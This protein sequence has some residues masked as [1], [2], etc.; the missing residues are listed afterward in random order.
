LRKS[1]LQITNP[2]AAAGSLLESDHALNHSHVMIAPKYEI[3]VE[4]N[5]SLGQSIDVVM[6]SR[7]DIVFRYLYRSLTAPLVPPLPVFSGRSCGNTDSAPFKKRVKSVSERRRGEPLLEPFH[8][9][10]FILEICQNVFVFQ[11]A[12]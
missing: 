1:L 8:H 5:E 7:F 9:F 12:H 11:S 10:R 4:L 2:F 6:L 3:F